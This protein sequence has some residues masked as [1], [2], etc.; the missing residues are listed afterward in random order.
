MTIRYN[1]FGEVLTGKVLRVDDSE[2]RRLIKVTDEAS[3]AILWI[4]VD[5]VLSE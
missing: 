2:G 4:P 5:L 3:G 1:F